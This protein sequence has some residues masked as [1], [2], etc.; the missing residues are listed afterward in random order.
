MIEKARRLD[1]LELRLDVIKATY[2]LFGSG[3]MEQAARLAESVLERDPL[4]VPALVRLADVRWCG[5]GEHAESVA[6]AEQ[7]VALDPGNETAWRHLILSYLSV[8]EPAGAEAAIHHISDHPALGRLMMHLYRNEWV[9]AG[10]AAYALVAAG[11][12][13][14]QIEP[15]VALAIRR[16]A[17]V[18]GDYRRAIETLEEWAAVAWDGSEPVLQG[19]LDMGHGVAAL[20]DMLMATGQKDRARALLEELL[21]D[22]DSQV[23]RYS[24]GEV[25]VNGSRAIAFALLGQPKEAIAVLQRQA[26]LGFLTHIWRV[27]LED[28]P[29]FDSLRAR[30][31]FKALI[32][33]VRAN[34]KREREQYLRM[35]ADGQ[36]Q[37][38]S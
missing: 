37:N 38:R 27:V 28:E 13:Y 9:K 35:R 22:A 12:T 33:D 26:Q 6:L 20:A 8:D 16:H 18:T 19:Q 3:D 17:R 10:E 15:H 30:E 36:V 29:A 11:P 25:W 21:A 23:K 14:R 2:L 32:A 1:P 24:R 5:Q 31:D 34:E 7:A 4:Y